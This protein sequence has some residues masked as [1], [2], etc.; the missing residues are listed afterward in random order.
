MKPHRALFVAVVLLCL[1]GL[2]GSLQ[3]SRLV[4]LVY[5]LPALAHLLTRAQLRTP[6]EWS[7][8]GACSLL[9]F[10]GALSLTWTPVPVD[11]LQ[12]LVV[13]AIG[14]LAICLACMSRKTIAAAR[15]VRDGWS[16]ALV[17]TL[18]FAMY[19]LATGNHFAYA[20]DERNLGGTIGAAPFASV[21][22]GNFNN[23]SAFI[24]LALP[25][26]LGT[27]ESTRERV[28]RW[29]WGAGV[30]LALAII[31]VNTN[32][33]SMIFTAWLLL[34][35][36]MTRRKWWLP[37]V[38]AACLMAVAVWC[39]AFDEEIDSILLIASIKFEVLG[40]SDESVDQRTGLIAAGIN[41]LTDSYGIGGGLGSFEHRLR[42]RYPDLIPNAHNLAIELATNFGIPATLAFFVFLSYLFV[43]CLRATLP[44][45][46]R[47]P[48][49]ASLPF[50]PAIGAINSQAV[51]Y[52]YW[53][54]WFATVLLIAA[55]AQARTLQPDSDRPRDHGGK[56]PAGAVG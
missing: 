20:L 27:I 47:S 37:S 6:A 31:V 34:Y 48:V 54:L 28:R 32:R 49:I 21:F 10:F 9:V 8:V 25:M 44:A 19:E 22:F 55:V 52:T 40:T 38:A 15:C 43:V 18:P 13:V 23:Y 14:M 24:S 11:G 39:G 50:V 42:E 53:W 1:G 7:A 29:L 46:L 35:Y 3:P 5:G 26:M 16:L 33:L 56:S 36:L 51:G 12:M 30:V 2:G 45:D 4:L 17:V 41:E